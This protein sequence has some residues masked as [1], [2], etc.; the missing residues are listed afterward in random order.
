MGYCWP[1]KI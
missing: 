1:R